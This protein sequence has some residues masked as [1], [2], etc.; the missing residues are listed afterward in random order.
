MSWLSGLLAAAWVTGTPYT[1]L[2]LA[3]LSVLVCLTASSAGLFAA[4]TGIIT[5][6]AAS[7]S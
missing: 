2:S 7:T 1:P 6:V 3:A 4:C 5:S